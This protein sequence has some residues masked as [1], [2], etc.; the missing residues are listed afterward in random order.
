M[1]VALPGLVCSI[2]GDTALVDFKGNKVKVNLGLVDA[3]VGDYVLVHAGM[4]IEVMKK[5][6]AQELMEILEELEAEF[7]DRD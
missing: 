4:A 3:N 1:C 2:D 6:S 7:N 5:D